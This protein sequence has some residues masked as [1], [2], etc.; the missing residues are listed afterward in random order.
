M[1][2]II[3]G[4]P[5]F[6]AGVITAIFGGWTT[7]LTVYLVFCL[8]D[9]ITGIIGAF[10]GKSDKTKT[11]SFSSIVGWK[12]LAKKILTL[13]LIAMAH[14]LDVLLGTNVIRDAAVFFF[15]FNE[16]TSIIENVGLFI[17][18]PAIIQKALD[19]LREQSDNTE[20]K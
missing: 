2:N 6:L 17:P 5:A 7:G 11:G 19:V 20:L 15:I 16:G 18:L 8:I 13:S 4:I 10:L 1:K 3:F 9:I 14:W 12:G